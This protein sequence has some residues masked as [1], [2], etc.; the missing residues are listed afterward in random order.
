MKNAEFVRILSLFLCIVL[1]TAMALTL[2]SCGKKEVPETSSGEITETS[3]KSSG[4]DETVG[5][6]YI[7]EGKHEF[8]FYVR[9]EDQ[10]KLY[11]VKTDKDTVGDAL[12]ELGLIEGDESEYGLFVK[13]VDGITADY[14]TDGTYWAFYVNGEYA[15]SGV[16][17][18]EI[19]DGADYMLSWE[20]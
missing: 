14:E 7:G 2:G 11:I 3:G 10:S 1:I 17:Q 16:D 6:E 15:M 9:T 13:K 5:A 8:H 19:T 12:I 20:K 4:N 18:T